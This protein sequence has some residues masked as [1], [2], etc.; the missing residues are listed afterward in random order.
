MFESSTA[1]VP[2][3]PVTLPAAFDAELEAAAD[4]ARNSKAAGTL[5]AYQSDWRA[6]E[7]FL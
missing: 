2:Y 7:V 3:E 6:F 5:R 4:Y 1:L